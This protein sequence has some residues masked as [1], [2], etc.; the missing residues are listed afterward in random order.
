MNVSQPALL[1][2]NGLRKHFGGKPVFD[3]LNLALPAGVVALTG[4]NGS[5]KST[6]LSLLCG[7][8][9]PDAGSISIAGHDLR[10]QPVLAK[11]QLSFV[12]DEPVAY[13][14]MTGFEYLMLLYTLKRIRPA[15]RDGELLE[16]LN[17]DVARHLKFKDMSLGTQRKF[18]LA[19]GMLGK[20]AVLLMDEPTNGLD[21]AA[22]DLLAERI[23]AYGHDTLVLFSTHDQSFID[24]TQATVLPLSGMHGAAHPH[25]T[26]GGT[27]AGNGVLS[28][29]AP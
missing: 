11:Q 29:A 6:L 24:A 16:L 14:F 25:P 9:V 19:G 18:M 23:C 1:A 13:E 27:A 2:C 20:P 21:T 15:A 8:H 3:N 4:E 26:P 22:K 12:P 17:I 28:G 5:G 10:T 7:I